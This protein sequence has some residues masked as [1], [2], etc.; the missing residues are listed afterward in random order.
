MILRSSLCLGPLK[1]RLQVVIVH[2]PQGLVF[3]DFLQITES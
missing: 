1:T 2:G 3:L